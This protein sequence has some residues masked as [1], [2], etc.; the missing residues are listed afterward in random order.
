MTHPVKPRPSGSSLRRRLLLSSLLGVVPL[1]VLGIFL[2]L[3]R[4]N[5]R[6]A[7]IMQNNLTEAQLAAVYVQ[8]WV[9]GHIRTLNTLADSQEIQSGS[10]SAMHGLLQRQLQAQPEWHHLFVTD[11]RGQIIV[12]NAPERVNVSNRDYFQQTK[13]TGHATVSNL[14]DSRVIGQLTIVVAYPI[15][16]HG[17]FDG[18]IAASIAPTTIQTV[19]E[20]VSVTD[21]TTV[22]LWGNDGRLIARSGTLTVHTGQRVIGQNS[23]QVF[24]GH[25]GTAITLSPI[26]KHRTL[27]GYAPVRVAPWTVVIATPLREALTP[28]VTSMI[29]FFVLSALVLGATVLWSLYAANAIARQVSLLADSAHAIGEGHLD[30]RVTLHSGDELESLANSLNKMAAD[31]AVA[32]RLKSDLLGMVSHELKTPLTSIL[33]SLDMLSSGI[34]PHD[35]QYAELMA[36]AARQSRRLQDMIENI[37]SVARMQAGGIA[38]TLRPTPLDAIIRASAAEYRPVAHYR[39]L[40]FTVEAVPDIL[41]MVDAAKVTLAL[42]NLLDNAVKFTTEGRI[43]VRAHVREQDVEVTVTD[44][45]IGLAQEVR[46]RLFEKFY[47]AEP[48]LTRKAGGAG[49][50]LLVVKS[51]IEAHGGHMI[52]ESDGPGRGSTFGFTLKKSEG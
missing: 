13:R 10:L 41:V 26:S 7:L 46:P 32:A 51:I 35:P 48:L 33:T 49:L 27:L 4:Y 50:G 52:V 15:M 17:V 22:G 36:I 18:I 29:L 39:G 9:E 47:Q 30:T 43:T 24:S 42:N 14:I 31:L 23:H 20:Q 40:E 45:G 25:S 12:T 44:T 5:A 28:V 8:G 38:L 21:Q 2:L 37:I 16:R 3:D 34:T 1:F 19:F 11:R 6:R